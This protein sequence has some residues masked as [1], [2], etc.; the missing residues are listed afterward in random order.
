MIYVCQLYFLSFWDC[1]IFIPIDTKKKPK[2]NEHYLSI[3]TRIK[4]KHKIPIT[5]KNNVHCYKNIKGFNHTF[6]KL[7][8]FSNYHIRICRYKFIKCYNYVKNMIY[9]QYGDRVRKSCIGTELYC[10]S[11]FIAI[12]YD[13][14][15]SKTEIYILTSRQTIVWCIIFFLY[16]GLY[17]AIAHFSEILKLTSFLLAFKNSIRYMFLLLQTLFIL[18]LNH[19]FI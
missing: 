2:S 19:N 13:I 14:G 12:N 3:N 6:Q 10:H 8:L 5:Q 9:Y 11:D 7:V 16:N 1:F 4:Y 18:R 15:S 17:G